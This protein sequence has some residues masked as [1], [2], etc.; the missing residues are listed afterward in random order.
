MVTCPHN[1][2]E[3]V[4]HDGKWCFYCS[5]CDEFIFDKVA[6]NIKPLPVVEKKDDSEV[7]TYKVP[8]ST[9]VLRSNCECPLCRSHFE[10]RGE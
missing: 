1:S 4:H 10:R 9:T 8:G 2:K 7:R 3:R 5:D 6:T